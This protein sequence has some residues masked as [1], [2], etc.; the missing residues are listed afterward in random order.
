MIKNI[1]LEKFSNKVIII[2][3]PQTKEIKGGDGTDN[4]GNK[5]LDI[6][7]DAL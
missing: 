2:S 4:N 7:I 6:D 5:I 3:K 1:S